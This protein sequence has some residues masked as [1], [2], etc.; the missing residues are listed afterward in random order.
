MKRLGLSVVVM[1][2][3]ASCVDQNTTNSTQDDVTTLAATYLQP[4]KG[5]SYIVP[6]TWSSTQY[7]R[8]GDYWSGDGGATPAKVMLW[9]Q[10]G[11]LPD[12]NGNPT[13]SYV[14]L[15][16]GAPNGTNSVFRV[17]TVANYQLSSFQSYLRANWNAHE[18]EPGI[19]TGVWD[20]GAG[21]GTGGTPT[22]PIGGPRGFPIEDEN[23]VLEAASAFRN[24]YFNFAQTS[25]N[26]EAP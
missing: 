4:S 5:P 12:A 10:T 1:L 13:A 16:A 24:Y 2:S 15:V 3:L 26:T 23:A 20:G 21:G 25:A 9:F 14:W 7:S 19:L 18:Q 6:V 11:A 8:I 22:N 17:Y